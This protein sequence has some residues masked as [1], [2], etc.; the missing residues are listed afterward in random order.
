MRRPRNG[1]SDEAGTGVAL[2]STL[3]NA[4]SIN[5]AGSDVAVTRDTRG[6]PKAHYVVRWLSVVMRRRD[7]N[8]CRISLLGDLSCNG[9]K[10]LCV[11]GRAHCGVGPGSGGGVGP[12]SRGPVGPGS[13]GAASARLCIASSLQAEAGVAHGTPVQA[14]VGWWLCE[15]SKCALIR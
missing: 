1:G 5:G 15:V 10:A 12:G 4:L 7:R 8:L 2:V 13:R 6:S 9:S 11:G 14:R 3:V